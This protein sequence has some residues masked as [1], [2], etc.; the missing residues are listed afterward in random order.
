MSPYRSPFSLPDRCEDGPSEGGAVLNTGFAVRIQPSGEAEMFV[1]RS[2][3]LA[4]PFRAIV[5]LLALT[6]ACTGAGC[7]LVFRR[8]G[9]GILDLGG[10]LR[11]MF[12]PER[13]KPNS[14]FGTFGVS[15]NVPTSAF[16]SEIHLCKLTQRRYSK[17]DTTCSGVWADFRLTRL[18]RKVFCF[19]LA[20]TSAI[21]SFLLCETSCPSVRYDSSEIRRNK[22]VLGATAAIRSYFPSFLLV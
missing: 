22:E 13:T 17:L 16:Y 10:C 18:L 20:P 11:N 1:L 4:A 6:R 3:A 7:F 5:L 19:L 15:H 8:D 9:V 2:F 21:L 12:T 14:V